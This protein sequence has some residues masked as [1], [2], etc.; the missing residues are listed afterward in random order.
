MNILN[1]KSIKDWRTEKMI[2]QPYLIQRVKRRSYKKYDNEKGLDYNF[3]MD[4]MGS[5]EF[6]FGSLPKS[7]NR[8]ISNLDSYITTTLDLKDFKDRS[9]RLYHPKDFDVNKYLEHLKTIA[10]NSHQ[11]KE[12]IQLKTLITGI[13]EYRLKTMTDDDWKSVYDI[14]WDIENDVWFTFDKIKMNQVI[15]S[16][17]NVAKTRKMTEE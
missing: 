8:I 10:D 15:K 16:I 12:N 11:L 1:L 14:L 3:E 4:Y 6:E 13:S 9:L 7:F 2:K 5:A 17:T